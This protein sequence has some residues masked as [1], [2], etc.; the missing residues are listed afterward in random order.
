MPVVVALSPLG[1]ES[2][3]AERLLI[4]AYVVGAKRFSI[5]V[6]AGFGRELAVLRPP[7]DEMRQV[8]VVGA[9]WFA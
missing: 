1:A 2:T 8:C 5:A 6:K 9:L 4:A 7:L 3:R